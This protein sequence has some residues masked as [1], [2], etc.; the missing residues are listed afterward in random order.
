MAVDWNRIGH[1]TFAVA[2]AY[3]LALP[4]GLDR[5][6]SRAGLGLRTF[7]LVA[8][9]S[10]AYVLLALAAFPNDPSSRARII[11]G[12]VTGIGFVGGGA[13]LK[14][15]LTIKGTATAASIWSTGAIGATVANGDYAIA[16]VVSAINLVT[17]LVLTPIE[18]KLL[19]HRERDR[20][21]RR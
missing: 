11:Q 7:P 10:C 16:I 6:R 17:F 9:A 15:G 21:E 19:P 1:V 8:V 3:A 18:E 14:Q 13:I 5:Q 2:V 20:P 12:L 4:I